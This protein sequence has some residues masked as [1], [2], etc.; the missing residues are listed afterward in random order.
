MCVGVCVLE[1]AHKRIYTFFAC[2]CVRTCVLSTH[3]Y[4]HNHLVCVFPVLNE[5]LHYVTSVY[6]CGIHPS[7]VSK[8]NEPWSLSWTKQS[9]AHI[10]FLS[11]LMCTTMGLSTCAVD[12]S[13]IKSRYTLMWVSW[14]TKM[15]R[16]GWTAI[17]S[18][19]GIHRHFNDTSS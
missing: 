7:R 4:M 2:D 19:V 8:W 14:E 9:H 15:D 16:T 3:H 12:L 11:E 18:S 10:G 1:R 13:L 6:Y 5:C 17:S